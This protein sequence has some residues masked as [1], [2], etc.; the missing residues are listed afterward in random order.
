MSHRAPTVRMFSG[1]LLSLLAS[2]G[3]QAQV[4]VCVDPGHG[5][6]DPG[7]LGCD[8]I[9]MN[10]EDVNLDVGTSVDVDVEFTVET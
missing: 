3:V 8:A 9:G 5:G 7:A 1:L 10:E 6:V 4:V 2:A